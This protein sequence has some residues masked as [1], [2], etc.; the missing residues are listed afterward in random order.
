M[1]WQSCFQAIWVSSPSVCQFAELRLVVGIG[2]RTRPQP[3][4]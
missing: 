3:V 1:T 4:A 2:N